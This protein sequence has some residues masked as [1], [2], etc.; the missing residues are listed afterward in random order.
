MAY[1]VDF[2]DIRISCLF[3]ASL[4]HFWNSSITRSLYNNGYWFP[5]DARNNFFRD[6]LLGRANGHILR[7]EGL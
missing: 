2:R 3:H 4:I 7:E 5:S 1:A 6:Y